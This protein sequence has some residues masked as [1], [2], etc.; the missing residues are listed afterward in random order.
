MTSPPASRIAYD[1]AMMQLHENEI[2][3]AFI[4]FDRGSGLLTTRGL[5]NAMLV[6]GFE[7]N[8]GEIG[9]MM[10]ITKIT[11][12]KDDDRSGIADYP[13]FLNMMQ[14]KILNW[15]PRDEAVMM[16]FKH[17]VDA[18]IFIGT[19]MPPTGIQT[20]MRLAGIAAAS[21]SGDETE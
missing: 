12:S 9:E 19:Y 1:L 3:N 4:M 5:K 7:P 18:G 6:L 8:E 21:S 11:E 16:F 13:A 10:S 15:H 17:Y 14:F 20:M 2:R